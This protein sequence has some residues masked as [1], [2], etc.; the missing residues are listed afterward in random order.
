MQK[1]RK[2]ARCLC[3]GILCGVLA[4]G[5]S[6]LT[7][8]NLH[9]LPA[10]AGKLLELEPSTLT[11]AEQILSQLRHAALE[12]AWLPVLF[13]GVLIGA[14]LMHVRPKWL[15]GCLWFLLLLALTV[16]SFWMIEVNGIR[17]GAA[18]SALLPLVKQLL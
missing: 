12:P 16:F 17:F 3:P 6:A 11:Y 8:R 1:L 14:G 2:G 5:I 10:L 4:I 9:A 15:A 13:S 7:I 18:L